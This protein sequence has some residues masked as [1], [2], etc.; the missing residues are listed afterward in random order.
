LNNDYSEKKYINAYQVVFLSVDLY[1][2]DGVETN[3]GIT[4]IQEET[5]S[6]PVLKDE[7]VNALP[8]KPMGEGAV[9]I[10]QTH[11]GVLEY[12]EDSLI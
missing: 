11:R 7:V 3:S 4:A 6:L 10:P 1:T 12:G 9:L 2:A 8:L 5:D